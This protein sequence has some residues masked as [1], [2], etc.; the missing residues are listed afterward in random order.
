M[1]LG[2][3]P[4][5]SLADLFCCYHAR[6]SNPAHRLRAAVSVR[7]EEGDFKGVIRM[8][9]GVSKVVEPSDGTFSAFQDK[10]P[11]VPYDFLLVKWR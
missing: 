9:S 5:T 11:P 4:P 1:E 3:G 8:A 6:P 10:H 7:L 2:A